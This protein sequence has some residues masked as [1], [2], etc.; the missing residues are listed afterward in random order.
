MH[1]RSG[2]RTLAICTSEID[3]QLDSGHVPRLIGGQ[4]RNG[5]G[6]V[7][8][9]TD[10]VRQR[11]LIEG[12]IRRRLLQ[13]WMEFG[14]LESGLHAKGMYGVDAN[15]VHAELVGQNLRQTRDAVLRRDIV[16]QQRQSTS[17]AVELTNT[18][19]PPVACSI[20]AGM[21]AFAV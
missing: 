11:R 1:P 8:G 14:H 4:P 21:A 12:R 13:L 6:D 17:P 18:I 7:V 16:G 19:A 2:N 5:R 20:I 15:S 10:P 9:L 3:R